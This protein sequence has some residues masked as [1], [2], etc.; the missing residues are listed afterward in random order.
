[1]YGSCAGYITVIW[2]LYP[3]CWGISEGGNVITVSHEMVFYGIL[4]IFAGPIFLFA[5]LAAFRDVEYDTLGLQSGKASDHVGARPS[6]KGR[7]ETG[8]V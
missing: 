6:E 7:E 3:I 4:D 5:F 1:M 8:A 2:L